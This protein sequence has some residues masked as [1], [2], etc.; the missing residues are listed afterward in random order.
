MTISTE[1][2]RV[3]RAAL[4]DHQI[5]YEKARADIADM[6]AAARYDQERDRLVK[7]GRERILP[8]LDVIIP[9]TAAD[10][11]N[12]LTHWERRDPGEPITVMINSPGGSVMD[13]F[14]VF[15]TL[16]RLRRKGHFITTHGSGMVASMAAVLLQAG[17]ERVLDKRA[18]LL[19]HEGGASFAKGQQFSQG[20]LEDMQILTD[21]LQKDLLETLA[22]RSTMSVDQLKRK[23]K[24]RD[25][26]IGTEEALELGFCDRIE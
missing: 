26:Y 15:D 9:E 2:L 21:M 17:D 11:V 16:Q 18:K 12:A 8:I 7:P 24:R 22:E 5:R 23:W 1:E 13:G 3:K 14:A 10:Y 25:W 6:E 20:E 19:I 4:L